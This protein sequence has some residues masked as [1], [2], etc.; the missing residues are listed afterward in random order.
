MAQPGAVQNSAS[1]LQSTFLVCTASALS[2]TRS[3]STWS[4]ASPAAISQTALRTLQ[5]HVHRLS[6]QI[7][8]TLANLNESHRSRAS[9]YNHRAVV[10]LFRVQADL[11]ECCAARIIAMLLQVPADKYRGY[12]QSNGPA[13]RLAGTAVSHKPLDSLRTTDFGTQDLYQGSA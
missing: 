3:A 7:C 6:A 12:G 8:Q 4:T 1:R 13:A 11:L 2:T 5:T 9:T 10:G